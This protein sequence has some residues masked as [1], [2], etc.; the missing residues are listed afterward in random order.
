VR[1]TVAHARLWRQNSAFIVTPVVDAGRAFD[2]VG[3]LSLWRWRAAP[4]GALR[5]SWNQATIVT[6]DHGVSDEDRGPL[7]QLRPQLLIARP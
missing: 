5:I 1:W 2:V 6:I 3:D 4:V 7:H